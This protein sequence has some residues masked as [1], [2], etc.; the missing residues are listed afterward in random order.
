MVHWPN[1]PQ[2]GRRALQLKR[3]HRL[4]LLFCVL[5]M[6]NK[7]L[8]MSSSSLK[9][10]TYHMLLLCGEARM[11][12][13]HSFGYYDLWK[14]GE[15]LYATSHCYCGRHRVFVEAVETVKRGRDWS[16][17]SCA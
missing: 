6:S 9:T 11:N 4:P 12:G 1:C 7:F 2:R 14:H 5:V 10:K 16:S 3:M 13:C 15:N 8:R 17:C